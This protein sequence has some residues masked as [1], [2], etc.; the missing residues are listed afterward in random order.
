[1]K[2]SGRGSLVSVGAAGLAG[3]MFLLSAIKTTTTYEELVPGMLVLGIGIGLFYSSVT[4]AAVTALDASQASLA[5]AIV[6]M[7]NVAGG[8]IG[9]AL[10]TAI[11][12]SSPS[13]TEG[14]ARAF[15]VSGAL[16]VIGVVIAVLFLGR[17]SPG[18]A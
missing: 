9:L 16:A 7:A 14:I 5:G 6:Y 11:V 17:P 8:A 10:N 18:R 1:M 15:V 12:V 3:G 13:L 4:T 2:G